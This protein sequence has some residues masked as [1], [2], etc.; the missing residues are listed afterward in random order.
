VWRGDDDQGQAVAS[1]VYVYRLDAPGVAEARKL[2][3]AK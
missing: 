2:V 3:V 1:G